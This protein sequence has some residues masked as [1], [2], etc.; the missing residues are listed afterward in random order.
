MAT[1]RALEEAQAALPPSLGRTCAN[2][3]TQAASN[4]GLIGVLQQNKHNIRKIEA[5]LLIKQIEGESAKA[6][7]QAATKGAEA[8]IAEAKAEATANLVKGCTE[9]TRDIADKV[10]RADKYA[11]CVA[12]GPK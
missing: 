1:K 6:A 4:T 2:L 11:A 5:D 10:V 3:F 8:K 12:A 9:S 7:A